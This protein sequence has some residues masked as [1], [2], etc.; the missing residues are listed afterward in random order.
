MTHSQRPDRS[1]GPGAPGRGAPGKGSTRPSA[2]LHMHSTASDGKLSPGDVVRAAAEAG[3]DLVSLTD[4]DTVDGV[5]EAREAAAQAGVS[6]VTGVEISA[7]QEVEVHLLA[8]GFDPTHAALRSLLAEQREARRRRGE[9]FVRVLIKSGALPPSAERELADAGTASITRPHIADLL[10][11]HG[12]VADRREAFERYLVESTETF[13]PKPMPSGDNVIAAV[14][15][16]GG[17][18]SLA[19]PGHGVPHRVVLSLIRAGL[20]AIEVVHPAHDEMLETYYTG[21][22][23]AHGLLKTGGSDFHEVN[24][25][26]GRDLGRMGFHPDEELLHRLRTLPDP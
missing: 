9:K 21:L 12:S 26:E 2:D 24:G 11:A 22:A 7:R 13:V 23:D 1:T 4:H 20:D 17:L 19:H 14:Q 10:I 5:D 6:F 15:A 8:Y 18:V 16:S 3:A 25:R